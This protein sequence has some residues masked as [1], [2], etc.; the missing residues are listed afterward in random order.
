MTIL[1]RSGKNAGA[2]GRRTGPRLASDVPAGSA[3]Y[4]YSVLAMNFALP[5]VIVAGILYMELVVGVLVA[6]SAITALGGSVY[7]FR[8]IAAEVRAVELALGHLKSLKDC[9]ID[10]LGGIVRI[11]ISPSHRREFQTPARILERHGAEEYS[12]PSR[13]RKADSH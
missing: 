11:R 8:G 1:R 10:I 7:A 13:E 3:F 9:E 12:L 4:F 2:L 5:L 6:L